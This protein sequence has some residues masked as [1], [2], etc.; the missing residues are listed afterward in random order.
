MSSNGAYDA[1][2]RHEPLDTVA[3][4]L[5]TRDRPTMLADALAA[6]RASV[7]SAVEVIVVD[8]AS[9]TSETARVAAEA[10]VRCVRSDIPGLSIARNLGLA[11]TDRDFVVYTD[12]D[13][14]LLPSA[15]ERLVAALSRR[16]VG[17]ATGTLRDVTNSSALP[18]DPDVVLTATVDGVDAGHGALMAFRVATLRDLG[19]FDPLLGAGRVWGG[20]EDLDAFCRVL[21]SG[22]SLVRVPTAVVRHLYTRDDTDYTALNRAYG[23][24]IGAMS[25]KWM[26]EA[27]RPGRALRRRIVRRAFV[28]LVRQ[29]GDARKRAARVAYIRGFFEGYRSAARVPIQRFQFVDVTLP[30]AIRLA[31]GPIPE[32][33]SA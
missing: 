19:G 3:I 21:E 20:A 31:P 22:A 29:F 23:L 18:N 8:S 17:A 30:T 16:N 9:T 33:S 14:E 10:G 26:S 6:I 12:D 13:C 5:C 2:E 7:S 1:I 15:I 4:V 27:R 32:E 28:R 11:S 24:G 25:R